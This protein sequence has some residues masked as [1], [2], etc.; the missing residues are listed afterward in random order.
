MTELVVL[1]TNL[2]SLRKARSWTQRDL[3]RRASICRAN[4]VEL[5]SGQGNPRLCTLVCLATA[6]DTGVSELFSVRPPT[7]LQREAGSD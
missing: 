2:R 7:G 4:V 5:E 3:A 1:S 6:L